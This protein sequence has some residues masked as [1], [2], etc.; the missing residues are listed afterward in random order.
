MEGPAVLC[1]PQDTSAPFSEACVL[2]WA[3][4]TSQVVACNHLAPG[5]CPQP[6][7]ELHSLC[8][9]SM[10]PFCVFFGLL[11][12]LQ[13]SPHI[14]SVKITDMVS[15]FLNDT[16][17]PGLAGDIEPS[18]RSLMSL[19]VRQQKRHRCIEQS[20]GLCGR[21]RWGMIWENG[22]ATCIRSSK[23]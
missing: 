18:L 10:G 22:I 16:R 11:I 13:P 9:T 5:L 19:Y 12:P 17:I 8:V 21:G 15:I 14:L 20:F 23:K 2:P 6:C 7:D 4:P 3:P 1:P